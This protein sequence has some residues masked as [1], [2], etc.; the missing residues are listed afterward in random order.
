MSRTLL[1]VVIPTRN[2]YVYARPALESVLSIAS[3]DFEVVVEDNSEDDDLEE[4][5]RALGGDRR[6]SY[7]R[8]RDR[9]DMIENFERAT[10]R[11]SGEYVT[12]LGDDD[13][14]NVE[15]LMAVKWAE[16]A[17]VDC[18][19]PRLSSF[20]GWPD[21]R[22]KY[23]GAASAGTLEIRPFSGR[24][25]WELAGSARR[26]CMAAAAQDFKGLPKVYYGVVRRRLWDR[27]YEKLGTRFPGVSPDMA[28]AAAPSYVI[29][30]SV[31]IDYPLFVPGSSARSGAGISAQGRHVGR[32]E[33][34]KHLPPNTLERWPRSAASVHGADGLGAIAPR[35]DGSGRQR[36]GHSRL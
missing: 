27:V 19:V 22:R 29:D 30:E 2:R 26:A 7:S 14:M 10:R 9:A 8:S 6:L 4:W 17:G 16:R 20:Y 5:V 12:V 33:D 15:M 3:D 13:G 11:A 28:A 25:W 18:I 32:L 34:Q 31:F 35:S 24:V 36:Y 23:Y 21:F 1:S